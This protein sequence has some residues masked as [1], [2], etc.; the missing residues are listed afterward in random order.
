[1]IIQTN[2]EAYDDQQTILLLMEHKT[3]GVV[4]SMIK[5]TTWHPVTDPIIAYENVIDALYT[6]FLG[7]NLESNIILELAKIVS[8]AKSMLTKMQLCN[9][10]FLD[11]FYGDYE[12]YLYQLSD[13][14]DYKKFVI[15][16]LK[17]H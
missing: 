2:S 17:F 1:M 6:M 14:Q 13:K 9:I 7:I 12:K 10:C 5:S 11:Q 4:N 8:K 3:M 15:I 16:F